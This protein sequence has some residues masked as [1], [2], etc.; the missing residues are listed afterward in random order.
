MDL[1][2][3]V[4]DFKERLMYKLDIGE[5]F[6]EDRM[7]FMQYSKDKV[8]AGVEF[9]D[10]SM[11]DKLF[12]LY[13]SQDVLSKDEDDFIQPVAMIKYMPHENDKS[14]M[15]IRRL[16]FIND[17]Y[18]G[19]GYASCFIKLFEAYCNKNKFNS[20]SGELIP[21]HNVPE[22]IVQGYYEKNGFTVTAPNGQKLINKPVE[23]QEQEIVEGVVL[24]K[25]DH[26]QKH[27]QNKKIESEELSI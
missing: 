7:F 15:F 18:R 6:A 9:Y 3:C 17:A 10:S 12:F 2:K 16:E 24:V 22:E 1:T 20:L 13:D 14:D 26:Y 4:K 11:Q 19:K 21:L 23:K 5:C 25:N 27:Q 8:L